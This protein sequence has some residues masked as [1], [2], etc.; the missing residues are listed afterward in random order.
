MAF[1][2]HAL[3]LILYIVGAVCAFVG[4]YCFHL[5]LHYHD[6]A[7]GAVRASWEWAAACVALMWCGG[8]LLS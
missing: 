4:A 3:G 5:W 2:L 1:W 8:W 6:Q 7:P